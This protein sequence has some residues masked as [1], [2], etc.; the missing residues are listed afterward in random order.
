MSGNV[1]GLLSFAKDHPDAFK[2]S[3]EVLR[4]QD[5]IK[6]ENARSSPTLNLSMT[7]LSARQVSAADGW[8]SRQVS[9]ADALGS[10][11]V[12]QASGVDACGGRQVSDAWL[13]SYS[14]AADALD[15]STSSV[16]SGEEA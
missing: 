9:A 3:I 15:G 11:Q 5:D 6:R 16:R 13:S 7:G 14:S 8:G 2:L 4:M 12:S 1:R 10:R